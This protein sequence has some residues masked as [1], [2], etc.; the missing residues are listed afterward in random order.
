Y[1]AHH[2]GEA[3]RHDDEIGASHLERQPPYGVAAQ[4]GDRRADRKTSELRP[5][6][7]NDRITDNLDL[8]AKRHE[9]AGVCA[10]PE[11]RHVTEAELPGVA[12]QQI[13]AHRSDDED[14]GDD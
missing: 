14:A 7:M 1:E 4:A 12:E 13:E 11:E 8:E 10:Y 5:G 6:L 9:R 3:D 2:L